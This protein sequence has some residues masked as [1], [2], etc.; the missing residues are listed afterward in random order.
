M[1]ANVLKIGDSFIMAAN[2]SLLT[3]VAALAVLRLIYILK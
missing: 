2:V 1:I 3:E